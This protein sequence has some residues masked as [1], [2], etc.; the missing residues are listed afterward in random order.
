MRKFLGEKEWKKSHQ[1]LSEKEENKQDTLRTDEG[2]RTIISYH[3]K[4]GRKI[5]HFKLSVRRIKE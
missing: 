3:Q 5:Y 4:K 2:R 1:K